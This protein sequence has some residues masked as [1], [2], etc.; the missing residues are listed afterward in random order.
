MRLHQIADKF[1]FRAG[2]GY[3]SINEN[4]FL[5]IPLLA[6]YLIGN[7]NYFEVGA[8]ATFFSGH[9]AI[10]SNNDDDDVTRVWG[11]LN[12]G[13]RYQ[14]IDGGFQFRAG[15]APAFGDFAFIPYIPYLSL[16]FA[17]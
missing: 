14:P 12:I 2:I 15:F 8:G 17:F 6:N 16:G 10:S 3:M 9:S 13:Y 5:S 11:T 4:S 1:G 7:K